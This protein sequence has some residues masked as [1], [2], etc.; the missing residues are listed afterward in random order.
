MSSDKPVYYLAQKYSGC[1]AEAFE[2]AL[3]ISN[4]LISDGFL[5]FSPI[6]YSHLIHCYTNAYKVDWVAFDLRFIT[7][8]LKY[9]ADCCQYL[10]CTEDIECIHELNKDAFKEMDWDYNPCDGCELYHERQFDSG[11]VLLF[12]DS[13]FTDM[14]SLLKVRNFTLPYFWASKGAKQEY[15]WAKAHHVRCLLLE[16]FMVG[17]EVEI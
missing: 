1:E 3:K 10:K 16:P 17:T 11:L 6:A 9:D 7:Q 15:D 13:C 8:F 2:Y 14:T 12:A 4:Q 5:V